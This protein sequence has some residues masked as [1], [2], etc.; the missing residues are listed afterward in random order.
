MSD[1]AIPAG[2]T[3]NGNG[4][5]EQNGFRGFGRIEYKTPSEATLTYYAGKLRF[6]CNEEVHDN[7]SSHPCGVSAKHDPDARGN[8]TKCGRHS[9]AGIAKKK[10]RQDEQDAKWLRDFN[11]KMAR[12]EHRAE[13]RKIVERIAAGHNDPRGLCQDWISRNEK[14]SSGAAE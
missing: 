4:I 11:L 8:P 5:L 3:R 12:D 13:L 7:Y 14:L 2:F 1:D 6:G 10:A 9:A